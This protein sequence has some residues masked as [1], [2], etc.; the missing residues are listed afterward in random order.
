MSSAERRELL[1]L[2][3]LV[4]EAERTLNVMTDRLEVVS[5]HQQEA[6]RR[7]VPGP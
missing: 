3:R 1:A 6:R 5:G 4:D 7:L 2:W